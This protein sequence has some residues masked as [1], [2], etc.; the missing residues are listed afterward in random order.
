M[1]R[2]DQAAS[3]TNQLGIGVRASTQDRKD[4]PL[5]VSTQDRKIHPWAC[6]VT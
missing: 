4:S 2:I 5:G 3:S 1:S 6:S